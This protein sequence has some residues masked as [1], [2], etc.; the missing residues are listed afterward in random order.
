MPA[1][2]FIS[3]QRL[4]SFPSGLLVS[5]QHQKHS[6]HLLNPQVGITPKSSSKASQAH[7]CIFP[8]PAESLV[9]RGGRTFHNSLIIS[10]PLSLLFPQL[11]CKSQRTLDQAVTDQTATLILPHWGSNTVLVPKCP[12]NSPCIFQV[13][14]EV[15][16]LYFRV[17][18]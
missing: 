6:L 14:V 2:V 9:P 10:S 5:T 11:P 4:L 17:L 1:G 7:P 18:T 16:S 15:I 13:F 3:S 8:A 12:P